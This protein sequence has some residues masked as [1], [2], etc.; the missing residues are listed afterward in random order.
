MRPNTARAVLLLLA[1]AA[2]GQAADAE[3]FDDI[4]KEGRI[5][6]AIA[7]GTPLS[8][9]KDASGQFAGS[10]VETASRLAW[11]D[12]WVATNPRKGTLD[13]IFRKYHGRDLPAAARP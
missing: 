5:R 11:I 6:V 1:L 13:D 4:V 7:V 2:W 10:D 8:S 12:A 9:F 3:A